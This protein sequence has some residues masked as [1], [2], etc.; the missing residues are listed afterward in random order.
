MIDFS[1][2]LILVPKKTVKVC[3]WSVH[4]I[5]GVVFWLVLY[6]TTPTRAN[7][8]TCPIPVCPSV[9]QC[10][11]SNALHNPGMYTND[12]SICVGHL[13]ILENGGIYV[14]L[15]H[16]CFCF[17]SASVLSKTATICV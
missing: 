4:E 14:G 6:S 2:A 5:A 17:C 15:Q 11:L 9:V 3:V 1:V 16:V 10:M 8:N 12:Y 13:C 7:V